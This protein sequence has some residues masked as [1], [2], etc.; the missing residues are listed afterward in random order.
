MLGASPAATSGDEVIRVA[1]MAV[2]L[3]KMGA[4]HRAALPIPR[5]LSHDAQEGK[6]RR[7]RVE[8]T[9]NLN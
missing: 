6:G 9:V 1:R 8:K 5:R 4:W 7:T 3:S 2:M